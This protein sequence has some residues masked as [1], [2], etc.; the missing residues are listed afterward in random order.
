[1]LRNYIKTGFRNLF[2]HKRYAIINIMGLAIGVASCLLISMFVKD[3][4]TYDSWHSNANNIF[5]IT[6]ISKSQD[7]EI[8]IQGTSYPEAEAYANEIPEIQ[9]FARVRKEGATVKVEDDYLDEKN[10]IFTDK[11]FFNIF[12]FKVVDGALDKGLSSL[13]SLVITESTALKYFGKTQVAGE[14]I[15]LNVGNDFEEFQ[16]T[17]VI[18]DHPSNSSITFNMALSWAKL[19]TIKDEWSMGMWAI[20]P[21]SSYV[22][23]DENAIQ[24][25]VI[26]KMASSRALHNE[27]K[28]SFKAFARKNGNGLLPIK[29]FHFH[30]GPGGTDKTQAYI[31]SS[32]AFLILIIACFN[33]ANLS[34][35]NSIS[36]AKEVGVR[37]TI[38]AQ[39]KQLIVQFLIEAILLCFISFIFGVILA[40][41]ALPTFETIMQKQFTRNLFQEGSL[42]MI[43]LGVVMLT[44]LLSVIYPSLVLSG[45]KV[46]HV[47][48]GRL[49]IGGKRWISKSMVTFQF[50]LALVFITV[51]VALNRQHKFLVNK[52]KGYDDENLVRLQIPRE[53]AESIAKRLTANLSQSPSIISVGAVSSLDEAVSLKGNDGNSFNVIKGDANSG[54][55]KTLGIELL[56]GRNLDETDKIQI[57]EKQTTANVLINKSSVDALGIEQPIGKIIGEGNYRIVGVINDFQ[58]FSATSAMNSVMLMANSWPRSTATTNNIYLRYEESKLSEVMTSIEKTWKEVLPYEPYNFTFVD[59]Y[60]ASLYKKEA[61]WSKTLNYSSG[62]AIVVSLMGLLGLVGL[63]A[64]QRKKELSIRKVM[65]ASVANLVLLL[66]QGFTKLLLLSILLSVPIAYYIIDEFLQDYVNRIEITALLFVAPLMATFIIA[67][68]TVSSITFKSATRNPIDDLRYE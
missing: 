63:S 42:L 22:L 31:L 28:E 11:D 4:L 56:E 41:F 17:S 3:E 67:W 12:D 65:G 9:R 13:E 8:V 60:N 16:V 36:R 45:L 37:K 21:V 30:D 64:S 27:G 44:S 32:I 51:T 47:F 33:F 38:G 34:V 68:L 2:K 7:K 1:M 50:L 10:L 66:N 54:Y 6:T 59:E 26:Q 18:Q 57:E 14:T 52:D 62:L 48:K 43:C 39:R 23:L 53:N 40:E 58:L 25:T 5:R 20:T 24:E 35:V 55:I 15:T 61:L 49:G 46:T 19:K 29:N